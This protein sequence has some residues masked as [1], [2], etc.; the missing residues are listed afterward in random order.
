MLVRKSVRNMV[1]V[2]LAHDFNFLNVKNFCFLLLYLLANSKHATHI[3]ITC[4]WIFLIVE[5]QVI[6]PVIRVKQL[7]WG[8]PTTIEVNVVSLLW[9][10]TTSVESSIVVLKWLIISI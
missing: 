1:N 2:E 10:T 6:V 3:C 4:E 9:I 8:I 7:I 5:V